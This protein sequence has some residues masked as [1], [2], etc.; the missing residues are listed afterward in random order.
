MVAET[1]EQGS[2]QKVVTPIGNLPA[3]SLDLGSQ[4]TKVAASKRLN[5]NPNQ[6]SE[7]PNSANS[8]KS[9]VQSNGEARVTI[10][11]EEMQDIP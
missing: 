4:N 2:T 3:R 1:L 9:I 5:L 8:A 7:V 10:T 11:M 6:L